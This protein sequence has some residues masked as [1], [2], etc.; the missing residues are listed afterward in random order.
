MSGCA[1]TSD[2]LYFT[3]LGVCRMEVFIPVLS[4]FQ[5]GTGWIASDRRLRFRVKPDGEELSA[6]VWEGP[7]A[8]EFSAVEDTRRFPLTGEGLADIPK[9]LETWSESVNARPART[10]A[11]DEA[12]KVL[13]AAPEG[14]EGQ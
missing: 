2:M 10:M 7:W 8:Y 4:H 14:G 12:R 3:T 5:N 11:E 13:P 9:W 6:E 1:K